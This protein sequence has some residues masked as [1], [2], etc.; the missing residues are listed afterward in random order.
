MALVDYQIATFRVFNEYTG[1]CVVDDGLEQ[2]A[3]SFELILSLLEFGDEARHSHGADDF[4]M[5]IAQWNLGG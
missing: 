1:Q 4:I 3:F 5:G 2:A